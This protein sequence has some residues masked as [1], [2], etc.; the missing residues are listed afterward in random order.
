[1]DPRSWSLV[2]H[3]D[4]TIDIVAAARTIVALAKVDT[5]FPS[6]GLADRT[7]SIVGP[8]PAVVDRTTVARDVPEVEAGEPLDPSLRASCLTLPASLATCTSQNPDRSTCPILVPPEPGR[9]G[10]PRSLSPRSWASDRL[11]CLASCGQALCADASV[12]LSSPGNIFVIRMKVITATWTVEYFVG[13]VVI[14]LLLDGIP[15]HGQ[16]SQRYALLDTGQFRIDPHLVHRAV[17]QTACYVRHH[18]MRSRGYL[19]RGSP[20]PLWN[21]EYGTK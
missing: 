8:L 5:Q 2:H 12:T 7:M 18:L 19:I 3:R 4:N 20:P 17:A 16:R 13:S 6:I 14:G 21:D 9:P 11:G 1:M 10:S 15:E